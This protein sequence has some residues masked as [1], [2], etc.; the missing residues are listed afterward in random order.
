MERAYR[1]RLIIEDET[2]FTKGLKDYFSIESYLEDF[3]CELKKKVNITRYTGD[4]TV[5]KKRR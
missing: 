2:F 1:F 4:I 3:V 5:K